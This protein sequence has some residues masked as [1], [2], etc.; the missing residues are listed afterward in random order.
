MTD[1]CISE[2]TTCRAEVRPLAE[3]SVRECKDVGLL[4]G[5]MV[6]STYGTTVV[7][8]SPN[9]DLLVEMATHLAAENADVYRSVSADGWIRVVVALDDI[10]Q[11]ERFQSLLGRLGT[12]R[13]AVAEDNDEFGAAWAVLAAE[14]GT[15]HTVHRRYVLN[16][17]PTNRTDV[18]RA[19]QD[20]DATDPRTHDVA[21]AQAAAAAA[22]LFGVDPGPVVE[23]EAKSHRAWKELGTVGG[24]FPWWPAL[25]LPWPG[26]HAGEP[27]PP[28]PETPTALR[29]NRATWPR[30][31][32][33]H[34]LPRLPEPEGWEITQFG[35]LR[36]STTWLAQ[37]LVWS[38]SSGDWFNVVAWVTPLY[39]PTE[40]IHHMWSKQ[41]VNHQGH[42]GF[43]LPR[44]DTAD[45]IGADLAN[46]ISR[47][48]LDHLDKIG[49]LHGF[50]QML[51]DR[52]AHVRAE[53]GTR[54]VNAEELGYTLV[55]LGRYQEAAAQLAAASR[56][57]WRAPEW[58]QE[59][60]RRA[61]SVARLL[62]NDPELAV[63]QLDAWS[64]QSADN[65]GVRRVPPQ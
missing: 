59:S 63:A 1:G 19:I 17:D 64:R 36:G 55:L 33:Q 52:Q 28:D 29:I 3:A 16:A 46:A 21:G 53:T 8:D 39:V 44:L 34:V 50:A 4:R 9:G 51:M 56:R 37:G 62:A 60:R 54:G 18:A 20:L 15:I 23:A 43:D 5:E 22:A 47:Q 26:P 42:R 27:V 65:L 32:A 48:A 30:F 13:V 10:E 35:A 14:N 24:P 2:P 58:E 57:R 11:V 38:G 45:S 6:V 61:A 41:M 12:G 25:Q 7:I 49:D 40:Y 31:A